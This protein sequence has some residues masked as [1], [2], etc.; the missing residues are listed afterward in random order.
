MEVI[1]FCP[2]CG[3][4]LST[5]LKYCPDCGHKL[6]GIVESTNSFPKN[7]RDKV[8]SGSGNSKWKKH[9]FALIT[10]VFIAVIIYYL[11]GKSS[12]EGNIIE[13]Q[14]KVSASVR[15]P[16]TRY[17]HAYSVAFSKNGKIIFPLDGVKERKFIKFDYM[18]N[19]STIPLLA[20]LTE[21]GKVI[22]AISICEPCNSN[23]FHI[24]GKNIICNSCGTTW[25]L[26]DL[27]A[28]SGSCSKYPPDPV[29]SKVVGNEI[30]ID[31][32]L[33]TGWTRRI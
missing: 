4:K 1:K 13:N 19:N 21:D 32:N 16:L 14:P 28:V 12:K 30:Q 18:A 33:I 8:L 26:N 3:I 9:Y 27:S 10:L 25:N 23:S 6:E 20:Y 5:A 29:P 31:E 11:Q 17:D 7:K 22:T 2:E 15:Y 24:S